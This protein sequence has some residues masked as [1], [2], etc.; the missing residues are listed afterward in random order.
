LDIRRCTDIGD[1]E[2]KRIEF[3]KEAEYKFGNRQFIVN[4]H[5]KDEGQ[6]VD[7]ILL[8]LIKN[9]VETTIREQKNK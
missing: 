5:F 6:T 9:D 2:S 4:S 8:R 7:E 1:K 3:E